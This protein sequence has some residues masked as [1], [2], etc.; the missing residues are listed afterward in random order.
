MT[1][2]IEHATPTE[3]R[4]GIRTRYLGGERWSVTDGRSPTGADPWRLRFRGSFKRTEDGHRAA[5]QAWIERYI[6]P[7]GDDGCTASAVVVNMGIAFGPDECFW[8]WTLKPEFAEP[9]RGG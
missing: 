6:H 3:T 9:M 4:A 1:D 2:F 8:T 7:I 5:A